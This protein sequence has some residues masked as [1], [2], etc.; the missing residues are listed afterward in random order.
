MRRR[1]RMMEDLDR[2]IR[3]HLEREAEDNIARGMTPEEARYAALRK[4]GN[5]TRVKEEAREV[6]SIVWLEQLW[7]DLRYALRMLRKSPGF[8]VIAI[9]TLALGIGANTSLFS[10]V[11]GVLLNPLPYPYANQVAIVVNW[12]PGYGEGS[13]SY[14]DFLDW[15]RLNHTF[16]SLAA[17]RQTS[18]NLTGQGDAER[19]S[20]MELSASFFPL[21][22]V[23][24]V[25]GRD[26]S[27]AEDQLGGPPAVILSGG[28]WKTKFGSSSDIIGKTLNLDGTD[29]TVVGVIPENFYFCCETIEFR[30]SDV[31]LPIGASKD[32]WMRDRRITPGIRAVGR[33]KQGVTLAQAGADMDGVARNLAAAY[34]DIEKDLGIV[35]TP[36][37]QVMVHDIR[38]FLLVLLAAVGFVLLIACVNVA[39]LLLARSTGRGREFAIRAALGASQS[40]VVLQLLTESVL[41][42]MAGGA[43]GL[44]L[45]SWGTR[46]ALAALPS[47]L[48][49]ANDV[50]LD[51]RVLLFTLIISL[52]AGI[53]FGLAPAIKTSQPDLHETL[54]EGGRGASGMRYRTQN[55]FVVAEMALAVVLLIGTGLTI[56]TLV[57]LWSVNPGFDSH[58]VL[59]FS[60]GFPPSL[61]SADASA[62]RASLR[63]FTDK[64]AS[65]PGVRAV[66]VSNG[67]IPLNHE[68]ALVFWREGQAKPATEASMPFA[69]WYRV[70]PDYL[71]VMKI[72]LLRGR[73]LTAQDDANS[74]GVCVIDEDFARKFFDN[75]DPLGKRLNFDLVYTQPLQIVGV[76]AHVKQYGLDETVH[77][78]VQA[79][80]YMPLS[81]LPDDHLKTL[82]SSTTG[83]I[84]RTQD[85]PD[86]FASA[87]R[88]ALRE[89]NSKAVLYAPQTMD[90][91]ISQS[92]AARR[93]A[94]ILL[95]VFAALALVLASI[96]IYGVISYIVGQRTHEIGIRMAL[97]AQRSHVLKIVL[98]QGARLALLGVMIGLAGAAGLTRLMGT[99]L[100]GVSATDPLTFAAVAI[101]L[102]LI[103]LAACYIPA[104]RA[105]RVDRVVALRYE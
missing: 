19:V 46:A 57:S 75:E 77:S 81:Q 49:R 99:I 52:F 58:N 79:Q 15:V 21:L 87:V 92:L 33:V 42:A 38:P 2:D 82:A 11:N 56:R 53:L 60:V 36:L 50:R 3:D 7:Q 20:A 48:P 65:V 84:I 88:V 43:L 26:F 64:I 62:I 95:A 63:Q 37:K 55:I 51:P 27:S 6:W 89:F 16:S 17:Y 93:F 72:R 25:I 97:G 35:V 94:V 8:A 78:P 29:Y 86:A 83:F 4:F 66:S 13:I 96:G 14:P 91:I 100:Y 44:L 24:P 54:K 12:F 9:L 47:A 23:N 102:T 68:S 59:S 104:R 1:K 28:F 67:A 101:V 30:L 45:A 74:P 31:Y 22:G 71:N 80:F 40:R 34:P 105:T 76:V 39:N 10:V 32:P 18:F 5:V 70:G 61:A 98:A 41:L 69:L 85:S 90:H 73:F 103:A